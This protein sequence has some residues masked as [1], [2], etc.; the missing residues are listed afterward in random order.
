[1]NSQLQKQI[2]IGGLSGL[3]ILVLVYFLLGGKRDDLTA[4]KATNASLEADVN[5]GYA[6]KDVYE[7]LKAEVTQ[8]EKFIE[9]LISIMPTDADRGELPYRVKKLADAA[10]IEQVSFSL[11]PP[12]VKEYYT[13]YPVQFSF[14]A[15][16]HTLGQFT[17]LVSGY[18]KII[19]LSDL[20][21]TRANGNPLYPVSV[22]CKV[23]AFVYNP[24]KPAAAPGPKGARP[25]APA[26]AKKDQGD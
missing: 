22:T 18:G 24:A 25:A 26:P 9:Q 3:L 16:Y 1:M 6:L 17:S 5:R 21:M 15:G 14:R 11:M 23:S 4:L 13:E 19:N 8:Q 10:G 7:K 12:A 20:Q 2:L